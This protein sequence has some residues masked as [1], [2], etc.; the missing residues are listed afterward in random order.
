MTRISKQEERRKQ[1]PKKR[2]PVIFKKTGTKK[3]NLEKNYKEH[4][5]ALNSDYAFIPKI[6]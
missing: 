6:K 3:D 5:N 2:K 4:I 1:H